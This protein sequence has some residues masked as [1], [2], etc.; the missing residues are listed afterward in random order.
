METIWA[1]WRLEYITND[2]PAGGCFLCNGWEARGEEKAHLVLARGERAFVQMNR[3]PYNGGHLL[4]APA[5]HVGEM[6]EVDA[7]AAAEIWRL[8]VVAKEVLEAVLKAQGVNVGLNQGRC[9]GAGVLDHLHVH[10]V[11]RW[12]GDTNFMPVLADVKVIPEG[13]ESAWERL[14]AAFA[15]RG[16]A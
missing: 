9:A 15:E 1:P 16:F 12:N 6:Q 13:L 8:S 3:Y 2:H 7:E 10:V 5:C 14:R 4:V 11:P